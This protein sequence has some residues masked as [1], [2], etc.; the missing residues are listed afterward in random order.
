MPVSVLGVSLFIVTTLEVTAVEIA[1]VA[2]G[3]FPLI[4][5]CGTTVIRDLHIVCL[6]TQDHMPQQP[7][8]LIQNRVTKYD[9]QDAG[10][11]DM[12][13]FPAHTYKHFYKILQTFLS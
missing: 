11:S 13:W 5:C 10:G 12:S 7:L 8:R 3:Q 4:K 2:E 1:A 9:Q 6:D